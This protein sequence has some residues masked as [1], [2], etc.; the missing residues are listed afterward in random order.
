V[1]VVQLGQAFP[2]WVRGA[3]LCLRVTAA[4]PAPVVRLTPGVELDIAPRPRLRTPGAAAQPSR[5]AHAGGAVAQAAVAERPLAWLR[6]L[7]RTPSPSLIGGARPPTPLSCCQCFEQ[8][9]VAPDMR[10]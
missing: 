3:L 1:G 5:G 8:G 2:V 4:A 10:V 9:R 7:V 6:V